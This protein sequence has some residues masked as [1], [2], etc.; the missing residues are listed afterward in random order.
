M[1]I[2]IGYNI[3]YLEPALLLTNW[4]HLNPGDMIANKETHCNCKKPKR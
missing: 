1:H 2:Q 3:P 4:F